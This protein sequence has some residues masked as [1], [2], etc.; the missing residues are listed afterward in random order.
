MWTLR[1]LILLSLLDGLVS[2]EFQKVT[3]SNR[4][5]D[6]RCI[7]D[8]EDL[9][10]RENDYIGVTGHKYDAYS[11]SAASIRLIQGLRKKSQSYY[12]GVVNHAIMA[13]CDVEVEKER[14]VPTN[15]S[16][17]A[18]DWNGNCLE[19][20][21]FDCPVGYCET[22][23]NCFWDPVVVG[24]VR[25]TRFPKADYSKAEMEL[26]GFGNKS[27]IRGLATCSIIG[28]SLA[29]LSFVIWTVF[30]V[31]RYC[32]CCL[33]ASCKACYLCSPI[34]RDEGYNVFVQWIMPSFLYFIG[35]I[36]IIVCGVTAL[37]GNADLSASA[38]A[39]FAFLSALMEDLSAFLLKSSA[40]LKAISNIVSDAATDAYAIFR[41][42]SYI[43]SSANDIVST[44]NDFVQL[45]L[46]GLDVAGSAETFGDAQSN[47]ATQVTPTVEEIQV[48]LDTLENDLYNNVDTI[49]NALD[50]AVNQISSFQERAFLWQNDIHSY[51]STEL[52]YRPYRLMS[53]LGVF[54]SSVVVSAMG[55]IGIISTSFSNNGCCQKM[56]NLM[57]IT[58]ILSALIGSI[59]F[60]IASV[61]M[62][63][64]FTWYDVC[65]ISNIVISDL[66]PFLGETIAKGANAIF[67]DT[68]SRNI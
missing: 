57:D 43:S 31:G 3:I 30:F 9:K 49:Q 36:I 66:E 61:T 50:S 19:S 55:F 46:F 35:L 29:L 38:S 1:L 40:P 52:E 13:L 51:E 2:Y 32:C 47:F 41:D 23:S 56:Q 28:I 64:S 26:I 37:I 14:C 6:I 54:L 62:F 60:V 17:A 12:E 39:T 10:I 22:T 11:Q 21:D 67:N 8:E 63:I 25:L 45:H 20:A 34:P 65:E 33:W 24:Q 27:Y 48:M 4:N 16:M 59:I 7:P 44:F 58:G 18:K 15:S 53:I 5:L 42:T 68:V